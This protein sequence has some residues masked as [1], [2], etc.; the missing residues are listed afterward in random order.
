M[1][2]TRGDFLRKLGCLRLEVQHLNESLR[3]NDLSGMEEQS[4]TIQDL[5]IDLMK[6]QRKLSR[7]EQ[8]SMRPRLTML[9]QEALHSLEISRRIL[10]DSLEAMMILVKCVQDAAGYGITKP[11]SSV[12][13]DR[14]A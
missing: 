12:M 10:D 13:I 1:K 8:L 2:S 6:S 7:L 5:L 9:R 11:G 3:T 14:K 4:R